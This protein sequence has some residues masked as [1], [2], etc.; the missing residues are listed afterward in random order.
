MQ[1][2]LKALAR[3]TLRVLYKPFH[4]P[5]IP[6]AFSRRWQGMVAGAARPPAGVE[7][8][9]IDLGGIPAL[10]LRDGAPAAPAAERAAILLCHGGNFVSGG[11]RTHGAFAAWVA[12]LTGADVYL[13]AYRVAPEHPHPAATDDLFAAYRGVLDLGHSP[14]R[15]AVLGDSAGGA[16]AVAFVRT[17]PEMNV[18]SPAALVL[19]SPFLDL[20]LSSV[21]V[22]AN[23]RR[24]PMLRRSW[25]ELGAG[26]YAS[27][28]TRSDPR[29]SPLYA[30]LRTL[31]PTLIQV[32]TDEV[33]LDDATRFADRGYAAGVDVELQTFDGWWHD[34]QVFA[35]SLKGARESLEDVA[36]FLR[37]RLA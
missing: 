6:L 19:L 12:R 17:L 8:R 14:T 21:S 15:S 9:E 29:I 1:T 16:L 18:P 34:F 31:P 11:F 7:R 13:P 23:A 5:P 30:D 26:A 4:G 33:L 22:G 37:R 36:A 20:T 25:L 28:L 2:I 3:L 27:G 10:H 32:G 24:D 35:G